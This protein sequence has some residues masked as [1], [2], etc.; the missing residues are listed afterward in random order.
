MPGEQVQLDN[1]L[2]GTGQGVGQVQF[3]DGTSWSQSQLMAMATT[4]TSAGQS[5]YGTGGADTFDSKGL[6]TYERGYGGGDTFLYNAGYGQLEINENGS[7]VNV[8]QLGSRITATDMQVT[9][10][11]NGNIFLSDGTA[12][13]RIQLDGELNG[14]GSGVEQVQ[15]AD[16]ISWSQS[17][18]ATMANT[19]SS[20]GQNLYG[21][22]GA[23][24]F[25]SK[26]LAAYERGKW[27]RRHFPLQRRLRPAGDQRRR[28]WPQC[29]AAGQRDHSN[30]HTSHRRQ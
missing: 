24:S 11:N 15:F 10:D 14:T 16:G 22:G 27:R 7:G 25:D 21:T 1:E 26:G 18:L 17:Q 8:L 2:G 20:A 28:K 30:R 29:A 6:A 5:L 19:G 13:D 9:D 23:D 3:A 4:G 12:G